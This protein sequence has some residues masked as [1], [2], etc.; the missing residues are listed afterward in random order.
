M[1]NYDA[2]L[3]DLSDR[4]WDYAEIRFQEHKSA[5]AL[6]QTLSDHGFTVKT[7]LAGMDTAFTAAYGSGHPVIGIL[8]EY[9]A[10]SGMSQEAGATTPCPRGDASNGHGCGHHL[11]GTAAVGAAMMVRDYLAAS[12]KSGT[13]VLVGTPA[14]EGGSGK[15]YLARAG[16]FDGLDLALAWHPASGNSV[17]TGSMMANC[18]AYFRFHGRS[19]HAAASPHLGR[20]ALDAVE[21]MNVGVNYMR[22]HIEPTDRIHYAV[23]DTGGISPNVVQSRA[24]TL[25][26]IR[27]TDN[28]KVKA[29]YDRVCKIAQGAALMTE[30]EVEIVFDKACSNILSNAVVEDLLYQSMCAV[31]LPEYTPEE[32][33]LAETF[34][35]YFQDSDRAADL[36]VGFMENRQKKYMVQKFR[37]LPMANFVAEHKHL[38]VY[39]AGSSDV[40]DCSFATPTAQFLAA[41]AAPGTPIHSWQMVAQGKTG[42]AHKGMLYAANV[43]AEAA[44]RVIDDPSIAAAARAEFIRETDGKPYSCPIPPEVQPNGRRTANC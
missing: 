11:L 17:M 1:E 41:V 10:L 20:S 23:L 35:A 16:V 7:G 26:L 36:S 37:E 39:V 15:A 43:L 12:G 2:L 24:E 31:P 5:A 42:L 19:A 38:D 4:I 27:S 3:C 40:G 28:E 18:Q 29:L 33:A 30:T 34:K 32:L 9:D 13:V 6:A 22:E 8:A 14:E 25:Y 21:L 44:R